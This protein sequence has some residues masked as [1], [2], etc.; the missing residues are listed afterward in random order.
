[1][2]VF[3]GVVLSVWT[4]MNVYVLW[5]VSSVPLVV[6]YVPRWALIAVFGFLW[7]S[8]LLSRFLARWGFLAR[9]LEYAGATWIGVLLLACVCLLGVDI[10]T[11]FGFLAPRL[12]PLLR[13]WALVACGVLSAVALVQGH[14]APVVSSYEVGM[15][16]LPVEL[17]G[18]VIVVASDFHLG[19]MLGERWLAARVEQIQALRPD[20]VVLAGDIVEGDGASE[21]GLLPLLHRLTPPLGVWAVTGNHEVY[22]GEEGSGRFLERAGIHMLRDQWFE[23]RPG[24]VIAGVDDLTSRRRSG[25]TDGRFVE[26]ALAGRPSGEATVFI[27]HTPWE[28]EKAAAAGVGLMLSAHTHNGQIWPFNFVVRATYPLLAGRHEVGGMPVI[29]CRGSGTWGPRMRLW[30]RGEILRITLRT[31]H[32]GL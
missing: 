28:A 22:G 15:A 8:Y 23:V 13:G 30:R 2:A 4:A 31:P 9:A 27:S 17:N 10:V 18:A 29:V 20:L 7:V 24:L 12:A 26:R 21:R 5:R 32:P 3:F 1:M 6:R 16:G 11:G 19:T 25:Q 14:R